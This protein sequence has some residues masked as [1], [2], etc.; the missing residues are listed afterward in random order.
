M[1]PES[2]EALEQRRAKEARQARW[3]R[4]R[5]VLGCG[6]GASGTVARSEATGSSTA[7][8][9]SFP[10][11]SDS[12]NSN[13]A[14]VQLRAVSEEELTRLV[15]SSD[16]PWSAAASR[17]DD[18]LRLDSLLEVSRDDFNIADLDERDLEVFFAPPG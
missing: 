4:A 11:A 16:P 13:P 1:G 12:A 10:S 5:L 3:Q 2:L 15:C 17:Q 18:A 14:Y 7:A 8:S 6:T 9:D